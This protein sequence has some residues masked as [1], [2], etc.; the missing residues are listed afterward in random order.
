MFPKE[1]S[2]FFYILPNLRNPSMLKI[3]NAEFVKSIT[4]LKDCPRPALP[5]IAIVGRSNVGKSSL[6]N[7]LVN[8]KN[9][10]RVSKQPGKTRTI[11]YI[12]VN[13]KFYL[14][15]LP[16]YGFAKVSKQEQKGW[17][18]IIE[19]YLLNSKQ[20]KVLVLLIDS[21]TG[22]KEN[23]LQLLEWLEYQ[24]IPC[25]IVATK[26]DKISRSARA[27][28]AK[29]I[30]EKLNLNPQEPLLFFSAKNRSG[31]EEIL[32]YLSRILS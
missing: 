14:V 24:R 31:R 12:A 25:R 27:I 23:D 26:S 13:N 1:R 3:K 28:Q 20:L 22:P 17:Q 2:S 4:H 30:Y 18:K 19:D 16:G 29:Q 32:E 15:D 8:V 7:C 9:I 21:K 11:N 6:I 5:E 10:A